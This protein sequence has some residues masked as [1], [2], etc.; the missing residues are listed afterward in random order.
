MDY[1]RKQID[2]RIDFLQSMGDQNALKQHF[3]SRFEY[4]LVYLLAYLWNKNLENLD[5]EDKEFVFRSIIKPTIGSMVAICR[6]LD[7]E[8]EVFKKSKLSQALDEYP[9]VRNEMLGHGFV[10]EDAP[11]KLLSVLQ[12]LYD[13]VLSSD[14]PV[15]KDNVDLVSV[16]ALSNGT[17]KGILYKND[18]SNYTPWS[19]PER[20]MN[21]EI[22]SLYATNALNS[23]FRLSPFIEI[24]SYGKELYFFNTIVR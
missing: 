1:I 12:E 18:G 4:V 6:K 9:A 15:L 14:L 24:I 2:Q 13:H 23:Y 5:Y 22:G 8:K 3:Q 7:V 11:E 16:T 20:A 17:Y 19:C 10:Y 21:F